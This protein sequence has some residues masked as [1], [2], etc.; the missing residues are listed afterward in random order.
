MSSVESKYFDYAVSAFDLNNYLPI[1][2][3]E[4]KENDQN[5]KSFPEELM[6]NLNPEEHLLEKE[7]IRLFIKLSK[8]AQQIVSIIVDCPEEIMQAMGYK[9]KRESIS[10]HSI[11]KYFKWPNK[12][13]DDAIQEV[14][15]YTVQLEE[16]L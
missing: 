6:M 8:E 13:Y 5:Y 4:K 7:K 16:I 9:I 15:S 11:K 12:K 1:H 14:I 10:L 2:T 3:F